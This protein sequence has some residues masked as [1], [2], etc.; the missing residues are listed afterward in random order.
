MYIG[1]TW[2]LPVFSTGNSLYCTLYSIYSE[3]CGSRERRLDDHRNPS[4]SLPGVGKKRNV[5]R[6]RIDSCDYDLDQ[7]LLGTSLFT[8]LM[9]LFPTVFS[10]YLTFA[11]VSSV[12]SLSCSIYPSYWPFLQGRVGIIFSQA[13]METL[14]AFF[15]HFPLFAIM[16]RIKDPGRL[17]GKLKPLSD[18][19][20]CH[21]VLNKIC[22][23]PVFQCVSAG[24][25]LQTAKICTVTKPTATEYCSSLETASILSSACSNWRSS[26]IGAGTKR[27]QT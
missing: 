22:R 18:R 24:C 20:T 4:Y 10:Y 14:L 21:L 17:P 12:S 9:F 7:L 26:S 1:F 16:L 8:L 23:W 27:S 15:N 2:W 11:S 6:N 3:V 19:Y 5:L 13:V 25:F